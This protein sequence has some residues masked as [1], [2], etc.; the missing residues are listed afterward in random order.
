[1]MEIVPVPEADAPKVT[2]PVGL[3]VWVE[4]PLSVEEGV[5]EAVP[6]P[7]CVGELEGVPV[8][9]CVAVMEPLKDALPLL[10]ADAP[11]VRE[12]VGLC[13]RVELPLMVEEGV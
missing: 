7:D 5:C 9:V 12:A 10:E 3:C 13:E 11:D 6:L 8:G 1:M 2:E 4:L